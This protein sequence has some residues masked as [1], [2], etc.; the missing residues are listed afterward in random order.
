MA[1][2]TATP[3]NENLTKTGQLQHW[4]ELPVDCKSFVAAY[5]E[6]GYSVNDAAQVTGITVAIC[7]KM[8]QNVTVRNAIAEL[9]EAVGEITFLNELW[10]KEQLLKIYPKLLGEEAI[11][12]I[13]NFGGQ[14]EV[15]KFHPDQA[16]KVLEYI[17]PKAQPAKTNGGTNVQVNID[18]GA[19]GINKVEVSGG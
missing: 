9:Q 2:L 12:M 1:H 7:R 15:R 13:D 11:P 17:A 6:S 18:L 3:E 16:L 14:I 10:V 4:Q 5:V 19:F 8:L